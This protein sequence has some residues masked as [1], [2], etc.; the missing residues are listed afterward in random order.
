MLGPQGT[1]PLRA[2]TT[3]LVRMGASGPEYQ[4][5]SSIAPDQFDNWSSS[6]DGDLLSSQ[7]AQL[8]GPELGGADELDRNGNWVPSQYGQVWAPREVSQDWA[9]YSNGEWS[10]QNYYGWTW[11]DYSPWGWAPYHYGRWF[12]NGSYGWC[13]WPGPR[14]VHPV[15]R[16]AL[17][18]FFG[19]GQGLGWVAL[20]PHESFQAWWGRRSWIGNQSGGLARYGTGSVR[21][22]NAAF[23]GAALF[24]SRD[25][26][27]GPNRRF[28]WASSEQLRGATRFDGQIP[29]T[30][31]RSSYRFSERQAFA[32]PR[33][34]GAY[35]R[36][37]ASPAATNGWQ[38]FGAPGSQRAYERGAF[39]S[40]ASSESGWHQFGRPPSSTSEERRQS[41][42]YRA[43]GNS[44]PP[45][46]SPARSSGNSSA[47]WRAFGNASPGRSWSGSSNG[48]RN[49]VESSS[50]PSPPPS[51]YSQ[52][53]RESYRNPSSGGNSNRSSRPEQSHSGGGNRSGGGGHSRR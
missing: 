50:R 29:V 49:G 37:T 22:Q 26:F 38:R 13:W 11:V 30:P 31:N 33:V 14:G 18:G 41:N 4:E 8:I 52:P 39:S 15:W 42:N 43:Y 28:T 53:A 6:R 32:S 35:T 36:P 40:T 2:G 25:N 24:A 47:P 44:G 45:P 46:S 19:S 7:S 51:R 48:N 16:P 12:R 9:P 21:F 17:V 3:V 23:R 20:A 1:Q 27:S 34:S 5:T 10:W